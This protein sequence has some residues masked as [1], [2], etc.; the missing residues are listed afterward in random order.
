MITYAREQWNFNRFAKCF[1]C[2]Y[3]IILNISLLAPFCTVVLMP[4]KNHSRLNLFT[5]WPCSEIITNTWKTSSS[6]IFTLCKHASR[7]F[8]NFQHLFNWS[9]Y[10][11]YDGD[12]VIDTVKSKELIPC[13]GT[14]L[15][16][17]SNYF[18]ASAF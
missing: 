13:I 11:R 14:K 7:L 5:I 9:V 8:K 12:T 16:S 15:S 10:F 4:H 3:E 1:L 2:L 17:S 18:Y 6:I